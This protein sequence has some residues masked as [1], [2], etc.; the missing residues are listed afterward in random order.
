MIY[1]YYKED[2]MKYLKITL[3]LIVTVLFSGC[4]NNKIINCNLSFNDK[5]NGY[6]LTSIYKIYS[7]NNEVYKVISKETINS[8]SNDTLNYFKDNLTKVYKDAANQYGGYSYKI[9]KDKQEIISNV[10]IDYNKM[11][12]NKFINNNVEMKAYV[13]KN[14]KLTTQGMVKIYSNM[15]AICSN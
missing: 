6:E 5:K 13:N 2:H 9:K 11:N 1:L 15:G 3:I 12:L 14:N 10:T 4:H 7:S 8:K